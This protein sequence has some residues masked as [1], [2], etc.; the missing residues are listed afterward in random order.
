LVMKQQLAVVEGM[1]TK[2]MDLSRLQNGVYILQLN[3]DNTKAV[4]KLIVQH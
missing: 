2:T 3:Q 1:N 4:K